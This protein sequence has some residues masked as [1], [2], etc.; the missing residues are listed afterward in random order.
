[1]AVIK[2]TATNHG[3]QAGGLTVPNPDIQASLVANALR[4]ANILPQM[5]S[6]I[7]AH[8]TG[9]P[10]GDPIELDGL[11]NAF[12]HFPGNLCVENSCGI[13]SIKSNIGH[14]EAASGIVGLLKVV[15]SMQNQ[16]IPSSINCKEVSTSLEL[17]DSPFYIMRENM[18]WERKEGL[19]HLYAGV[20]N[21]GSG[22]AN[23]HVVLEDYYSPN[24]ESSPA[25][26]P[27]YLIVL[28]GKTKEALNRRFLQLDNWIEQEG[29]HYPIQSIS[30]ALL[31][32]RAHFKERA[33]FVVKDAVE[34]KTKLAEVLN[35]GKT[36]QYIC[37]TIAEGGND[38]SFERLAAQIV[39]DLGFSNP[40]LST[41]KYRETMVELSNLYVKGCEFDGRPLFQNV[42]WRH[43]KLPYYPFASELFWLPTNRKIK[44]KGHDLSGMH[45][46][47]LIHQNISN[48]HEQLFR[49]SFKG[50]EFFLVDHMVDGQKV[51]PGV[52]YLEMALAATEIS[53]EG[54][55][56][57]SNYSCLSEVNWIRT[58]SPENNQYDVRIKL[59]PTEDS[60]MSFE[61]FGNCP[62]HGPIIYCEGIVKNV[63]NVSPIVPELADLQSRCSKKSYLQKNVMNG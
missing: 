26:K 44:K 63:G 39:Y 28:S 20:S 21:F 24:R 31:L 10:L 14:L 3:G 30:A 2:G 8:G 59:L 27:C 34:L 36:K 6:Y 1:M 38:E 9:T 37:G 62:E 22:G 33:A 50:E 16:M 11:K 12:N 32:G 13:G 29:Y 43:V 19:K 46:H 48:M 58:Y 5:V 4:S 49:S 60:N 25:E 17:E 40:M 54:T 51:L 35:D 15:L 55:G 57:E 45:L 41:G 47:P 56:K 53:M 23:A 61:I 52:T 7:E 42:L 18:P